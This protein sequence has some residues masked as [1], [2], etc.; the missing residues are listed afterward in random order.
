MCIYRY[1]YSIQPKL[2]WNLNVHGAAYV[3]EQEYNYANT[4]CARRRQKLK[5]RSDPMR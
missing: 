2:K 4:N 3:A 5:D 1:M